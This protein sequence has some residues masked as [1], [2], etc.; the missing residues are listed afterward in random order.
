MVEVGHVVQYWRKSRSRKIGAE[1]KKMAAIVV[2]VKGGDVVNLQV[3]PN[4][5][6]P[7]EFVPDVERVKFLGGPFPIDGRSLVGKWQ[8]IN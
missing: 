6:G 7:I 2:A 4:G 3:L 5:K 8:P 1:P